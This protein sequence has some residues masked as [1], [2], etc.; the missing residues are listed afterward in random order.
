MSLTVRADRYSEYLLNRRAMVS[1]TARADRYSEKDEVRLCDCIITCKVQHHMKYRKLCDMCSS[2]VR[3][4]QHHL[5]EMGQYVAT[6][7]N[8][9]TPQCHFLLFC[10]FDC[11]YLLLAIYWTFFLAATNQLKKHKAIHKNNI[12]A[13]M[14]FLERMNFGH[15][16]SFFKRVFSSTSGRVPRMKLFIPSK[17]ETKGKKIKEKAKK[18]QRI[19]DGQQRKCSFSLP[20]SL[21]VNGP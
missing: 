16:E 15:L 12:L 4:K 8:V 13:I 5:I 19:N 11:D 1:L 10:T 9:T 3:K 2:S 7:L 17:M 6:T 20:C 18:D 21:S 14:N